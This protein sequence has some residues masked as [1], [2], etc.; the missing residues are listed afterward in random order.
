MNVNAFAYLLENKRRLVICRS[1]M[2]ATFRPLAIADNI[3]HMT[4]ILAAQFLKVDHLEHSLID[5]EL[6]ENACLW[7]ENN[8]NGTLTFKSMKSQASTL[9]CIQFWHDCYRYQWR[10][11][12]HP[13]TI[14]YSNPWSCP[15]SLDSFWPEILVPSKSNLLAQLDSALWDL[16]NACHLPP[17]HQNKWDR[18]VSTWSTYSLLFGYIYGECW[19]RQGTLYFLSFPWGRESSVRVIRRCGRALGRQ[20]LDEIAWWCW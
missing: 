20:T 14:F 5:V 4:Q 16:R 11:S 7:G 6:H 12:Y 1:N 8:W 19:F 2:N 3:P 18:Q 9:V 17:L 10:S 15:D 13:C